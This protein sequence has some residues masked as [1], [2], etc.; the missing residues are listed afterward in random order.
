MIFA[1]DIADKWLYPKY[2]KN[3]YNL[4]SEKKKRNQITQ[5]NMSWGHG[6]EF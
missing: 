6:G 3:S 2:T 5:L 1:N 4:T